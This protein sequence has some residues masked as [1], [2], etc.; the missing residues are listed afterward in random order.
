[1]PRANL[2]RLLADWFRDE[3]EASPPRDPRRT[4]LCIRF[5]ELSAVVEENRELPPDRAAHVRE[6]Q[7]CQQCLEAYR[8]ADLAAEPSVTIST[9]LEGQWPPELRDCLRRW[10]K[11]MAR[12]EAGE[13]PAP[14]HFDDEG[15]L[16]VRLRG[17]ETEGPVTVS[18][19]WEGAELPLARGTVER[20]TLHVTEPLPGLGV[21]NV[22][23]AQ[24]LLR[25]RPGENS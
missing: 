3:V 25:V 19:M 2:G 14:A 17:L 24:R 1:M 22:E 9:G 18:L 12:Q 11:K 23:V 21:R 15:T 8:A 7:W 20:G 5:D 4:P 6:C 16:H 10:L 13:T